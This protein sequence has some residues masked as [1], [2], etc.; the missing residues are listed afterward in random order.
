MAMETQLETQAETWQ[1]EM[2]EKAGRVGTELREWVE[3][4]KAAW[5]GGGGVGGGGGRG[6][7]VPTVASVEEGV[8]NDDEEKYVMN[9][10]R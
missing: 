1:R 4:E 2:E 5:G 8:Q 9:Y 6:V 7:E 10:D 3:E